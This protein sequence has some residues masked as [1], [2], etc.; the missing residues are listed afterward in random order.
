MQYGA[1]Q[2]NACRGELNSSGRDGQ[3]AGSRSSQSPRVENASATGTP[4][5]HARLAPTIRA[6]GYEALSFEC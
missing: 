3:F 6:Q 1:T 2:S 5:R 4:L